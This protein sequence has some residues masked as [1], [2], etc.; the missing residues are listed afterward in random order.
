M[1]LSEAYH[2]LGLPSQATPTEVKAA[3]RRL[4][5]KVHPDQ[6]GSAADFIRVRAAY[7]IVAGFLKR[8]GATDTAA[9][10]R[11][12]AGSGAASGTAAGAR[13]DTFADEDEI[14]VPEDL[15]AVIDGIVAEFREQQRWA[16]TE[17]LRQLA[18]FEK[19]MSEYIQQASRAELRQFSGAFR[20]SW[21]AVINA[22]FQKCNRK[23]DDILARYESWYT[24]STQPVFDDMYRKD[25]LSFAWRRYFWEVLAIVGGIAA[26]LSFVIGWGASRRWISIAVLVVAIVIAFAFY[27]RSARRRRKVREKAEPL[28]VVPFE[29]LPENGVFRTEAAMRRGRRTTAAF[30]V[31]GLFLGGAAAGGLAVPAVAAMAGAALG[32]AFDRFVNPTPRMRQGMQADLRRFMAIARPEVVGYVLDAHQELL[33]DVRGRITESYQERVKSTVKLLTAGN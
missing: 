15:R 3:Y 20:S 6:G 4:A 27:W 17:A 9:G 5:A 31:A 14:P 8:S 29:L 13:A 24:E 2:I 10:A 23:S 25:L 26:A 12:A 33:A 7:E 30:G 16:E 28:S 18:A 1:T 19:H 32:G 22:L 21:N 11:A